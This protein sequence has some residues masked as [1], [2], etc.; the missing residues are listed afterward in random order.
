MVGVGQLLSKPTVMDA[1]KQV[2]VCVEGGEWEW[3]V[4]G[5][6]VWIVQLVAVYAL[7]GCV[8]IVA[9]FLTLQHLHTASLPASHY[10]SQPTNNPSLFVT[11]QPLLHTQT[12]DGRVMAAWEA[13]QA[14]WQVQAAHLSALTTKDPGQ[15]TLNTGTLGFRCARG[16]GLCGC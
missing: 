3:G 16:V 6:G 7:V 2:W 8:C 12:H 11:L 14:A 10:C 15:L 5:F 9:A 1:I 13:Q 4:R